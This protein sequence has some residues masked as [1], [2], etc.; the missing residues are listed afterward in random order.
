MLYDGTILSPHANME[1]DRHTMSKQQN[2]ASLYGGIVWLLAGAALLTYGGIGLTNTDVPGVADLVAFIHSAE[3][4]YLYAAAFLSVFIEGLYFLGSFFPGTTL[5]LLIAIAAQ[6]GGI[7]M[8]VGIMGTIYVGWLLAG[9]C[10]IV[11]AKYFSRTLHLSP[12]QPEELDDN[13]GLTWFPAFRANTE[14][15]QITEGHSVLSVLRSSIRVKTYTIIGAS[16]YAFLIPFIVDLQNVDNEEGFWSLGIIALI[17]FA[18]GGYK[19]REYQ[20]EKMPV[21]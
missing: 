4:G 13:A 20:K 15:A 2:T 17:N 6:T 21:Q 1:T 16:F 9:I 3:G 18:V 14:V 5:V 19:L 7:E 12:P 11:L 10:N 8:F